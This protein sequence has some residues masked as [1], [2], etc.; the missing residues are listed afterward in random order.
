MAMIDCP[1]CGAHISDA[2]QSCPK[3][4][5]PLGGLITIQQTS[6]PYKAVQL[7]GGVLMLG[8]MVACSAGA[9]AG[10]YYLWMGGIS[11]YV[12]AKAGAWWRN[13]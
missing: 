7:L 9:D 4:G 6:K 10:S 3:C 1:E 11:C 8:G 2:A 13:G 12:F 5:K